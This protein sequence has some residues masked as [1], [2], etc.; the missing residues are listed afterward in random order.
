MKKAKYGLLLQ[1]FRVRLEIHHQKLKKLMLL[2]DSYS[3]CRRQ[4][5]RV[6]DRQKIENERTISNLRIGGRMQLVAYPF[7]LSEM[8]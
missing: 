5:K 1:G 4:A 8:D 2:R 3:T 6:R 7:H